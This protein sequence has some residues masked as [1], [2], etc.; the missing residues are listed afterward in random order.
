[1]AAVWKEGWPPAFD[2]GF[3]G[4]EWK[5][6]SLELEAGSWAAATA[7]IMREAA[8]QREAEI[9]IRHLRARFSSF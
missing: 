6:G 7:G 9:L 3:R 5:E 1:M 2:A 4:V 8:R